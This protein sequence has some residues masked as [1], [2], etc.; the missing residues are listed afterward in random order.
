MTIRASAY[1]S[2]SFSL[3]N[4]YYNSSANKTYATVNV[5]ASWR[6]TPFFQL[7]DQLGIGMG[8][9]VGN[10]IHQSS[11]CTATYRVSNGRTFTATTEKEILLTTAVIFK[12]PMQ[13]WSSSLNDAGTLVSIS[14]TFTATVSNRVNLMS[15]RPCYAHQDVQIGGGIGLSIGVSGIG[16]SFDISR[17]FTREWYPNA[18]SASL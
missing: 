13:K 14:A 18:K 10:F 1:V 4:Y 3:S 2:G 17:G 16:I 12:F 11:S 15:Y 8:A 7:K 9:G 5:S 6:G